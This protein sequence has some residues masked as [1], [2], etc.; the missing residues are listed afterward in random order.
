[1]AELQ[2]QQRVNRIITL[3]EDKKG[4][5]IEVFDLRGK[6]YIVDKVIIVSAMI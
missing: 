2:I 3:L 1:M 6:D 5:D 4:E